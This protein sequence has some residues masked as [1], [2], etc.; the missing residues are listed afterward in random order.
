MQRLLIVDDDPAIRDIFSLLLTKHGYEVTAASG[1]EECLDKLSRGTPDLVLLD[2]MMHPIDGWETLTAIKKNPGTSVIP[3][4]M[5]SGKSPSPD[6]IFNY[7]GWIE[8]YF[9]KPIGM[10]TITGSLTSVFERN[11]GNQKEREQY[12]QNGADPFIIEEYL[13]L[14]RFFFIHDKFSREL[15]GSNGGSGQAVATRKVRYEELRHALST[16][17]S[18]KNLADREGV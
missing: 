3:T 4:I 16:G 10:K 15:Y 5:F 9:M 11:R 2:I 13:S 12:L 7:G 14:K 1:G 8:D 17:I 18:Q 6:E